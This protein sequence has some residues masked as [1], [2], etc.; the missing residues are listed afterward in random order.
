MCSAY[1]C[2]PT[3]RNSNKT[4]ESCLFSFLKNK[5][6]RYMAEHKMSPKAAADI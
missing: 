5:A 3:A 4:K 1:K 6:V 2:E